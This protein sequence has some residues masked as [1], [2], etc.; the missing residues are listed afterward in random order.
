MR[1]SMPVEAG[2]GTETI[3]RSGTITNKGWLM[4]QNPLLFLLPAD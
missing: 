1:K 4:E 2:N 3:S